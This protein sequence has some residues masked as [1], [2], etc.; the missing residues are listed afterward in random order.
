MLEDFRVREDLLPVFRADREENDDRRIM[1][2]N[3]RL[4]HRMFAALEGR[5][6]S[7]PRFRIIRGR[8]GA[9]PSSVI[10]RGHMCSITLSPK[11]EHL[12]SVAPSICRAKS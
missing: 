8:D 10:G 12:I 1:V 4:M 6:P 5:P 3:D 11:A 2:F 7:R 9:R